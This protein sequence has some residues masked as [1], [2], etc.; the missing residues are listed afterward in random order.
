MQNY[1]YSLYNVLSA[2]YAD[3]FVFPSDGFALRRLSEIGEKNPL[4]L[5][6]CELK[7]VGTQDISTGLITPCTPVGIPWTS[8]PP[9]ESAMD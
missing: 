2:R 7:R 8:A 9:L 1:V 4:I 3:I 5:N 6:E